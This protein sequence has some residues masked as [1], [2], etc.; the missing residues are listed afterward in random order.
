MYNISK[1]AKGEVL[2]YFNL[3]FDALCKVMII[4]IASDYGILTTF[5]FQRTQ[6]FR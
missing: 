5:S 2:V 1:V 3:I 6:S 4:I